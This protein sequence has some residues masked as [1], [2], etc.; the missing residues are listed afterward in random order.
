MVFDCYLLLAK[1]APVSSGKVLP[2]SYYPEV[3]DLIDWGI[4]SFDPPEVSD[5]STLKGYNGITTD[6][7]ILGG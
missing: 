3:V 4:G 6:Q 2:L 1:T 7:L 5:T